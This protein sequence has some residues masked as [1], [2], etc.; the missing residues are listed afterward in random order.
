MLGVSGLFCLQVSVKRQSSLLSLERAVSS[1]SCPVP[2]VNHPLVHVKIILPCGFHTLATIIDSK[3]D[4]RIMDE[5]L[6]RRLG[7]ANCLESLIPLSYPVSANALDGHLLGSVSHHSACS[8]RVH[9][10][11][12]YS[13]GLALSLVL[14][15]GVPLAPS[16]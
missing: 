7:I 4:G 12:H 16:T 5:E 1:I 6:A 10:S 8:C 2:P 9:T 3:A 14:D 15:F 13:S 11:R